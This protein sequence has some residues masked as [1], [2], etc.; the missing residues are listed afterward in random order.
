[1]PETEKLKLINY[2]EKAKKS[3]VYPP[4][5]EYTQSNTGATNSDMDRAKKCR[6]WFD[7][8]G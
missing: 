5:L 4:V 2:A 3:G 6:S 1:M 7:W 8:S